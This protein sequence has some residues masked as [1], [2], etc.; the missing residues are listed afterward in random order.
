MIY[1]TDSFFLF[2]HMFSKLSSFIVQ[3]VR[4]DSRIGINE[5]AECGPILR[6]RRPDTTLGR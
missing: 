2:Q 4:E 6:Q 3:S 1:K 5:Y